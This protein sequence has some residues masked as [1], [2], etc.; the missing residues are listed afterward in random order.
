MARKSSRKPLLVGG[1]LIGILV[2]GIAGYK[3][4]ARPASTVSSTRS[5]S[6]RKCMKP[7]PR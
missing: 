4:L 7:P 2:F 5:T 1:V 6:R 3:V